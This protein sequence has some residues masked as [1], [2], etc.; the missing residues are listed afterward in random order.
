METKTV[1]VEKV[2]RVVVIPT[3]GEPYWHEHRGDTLPMLQDKCGGWVDVICMLDLH[4]VG[5]LDLWVNDESLING[6]EPNKAA[7]RV[8]WVASPRHML[9]R[10]IVHGPAVLALNDTEGETVSVTREL[11]EVFT[12]T[13]GLYVDEVQLG[14]REYEDLIADDGDDT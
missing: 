3:D 1:K 14:H 4:G 8:L 7:T 12:D 11:V 5:C 13:I 10:Y 2:T 6:M 9:A